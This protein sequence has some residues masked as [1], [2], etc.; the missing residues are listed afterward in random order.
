[1]Y[2]SVDNLVALELVPDHHLLTAMRLIYRQYHMIRCKINPHVIPLSA[3]LAFSAEIP[4]RITLFRHL[5]SLSTDSRGMDTSVS[6]AKAATAM[7]QQAMQ[8]IDQT[9]DIEIKIEIIKTLN[10]VS[11]REIFVEIE[12]ARLI[13]RLAKINEEQGQIAEAADLM[14]KIAVKIYHS[15]PASHILIGKALCKL[16]ASKNT[17][18]INLNAKLITA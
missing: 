9:P 3:V 14:Q 15:S 12:R 6:N 5:I 10:N 4:Q 16:S 8:Y 1:F 18:N 13:K 2:E 7:V 17:V 11:T